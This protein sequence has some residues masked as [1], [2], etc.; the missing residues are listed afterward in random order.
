MPKFVYIFFALIK[1]DKWVNT[2]NSFNKQ[3]VLG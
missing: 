3:V 2:T 1:F